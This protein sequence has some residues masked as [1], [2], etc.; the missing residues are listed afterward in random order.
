MRNIVVGVALAGV[1]LAGCS[2]QPDQQEQVRD[3]WIEGCTVAST[4][5]SDNDDVNFWFGFCAD[6][7][8]AEVAG[9]ERFDA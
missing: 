9:E 6:F 1:L 4:A 3:A 2:T 7:Y 8:D 5:V